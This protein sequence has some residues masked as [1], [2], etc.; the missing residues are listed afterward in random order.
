M[1]TFR[2]FPQLWYSMEDPYFDK[3]ANTGF[4]H[5]A[6]A[7]RFSIKGF[8]SALRH[9]SAFRQESALLVVLIPVA[10]LISS[11]VG[12]FLLLMVVSLFVM[13]VELLNSAVEATVDR[14]GEEHHELS[15]R[16]KDYGSAAVMLS[17]CMAGP[18]W[19]FMIYRFFAS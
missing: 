6:N 18:V 14:I 7:A 12:D 1:A 19:L 5:L 3:S 17:L 8:A 11:S 16:A 4:R 10:I 13:V 2:G 15:G 9:E